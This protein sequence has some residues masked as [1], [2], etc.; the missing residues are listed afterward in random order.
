MPYAESRDG[1]SFTTL[2]GPAL[3]LG[4]LSRRRVHF[5]A[6]KYEKERDSGFLSS[7]GYSSATVATTVDSV[8]SMEVLYQLCTNYIYVVIE[9]V[10]WRLTL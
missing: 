10:L 3:S 2:F 6:L 5:E 7:F 4:I 9:V 1:A 8:C